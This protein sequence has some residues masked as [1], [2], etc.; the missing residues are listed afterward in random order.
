MNL[1]L[2]LRRYCL[3]G[4]IGLPV[5]L[6]LSACKSTGQLPSDSELRPVG[7]NTPVSTITES[8]ARPDLSPDQLRAG[9]RISISFSGLPTPI[10]KHEEQIREDG[11]INPPLLGIPIKAAGK[12]IGELQ[13]ELQDKYVPSYWRSATVT[14]RRME[15]YYFVGGEVRNPG[16]KPYLSQMT[17]LKAIEAGGGFTEYGKRSSVQIIRVTGQKEKVNCNRALKD[18]A[19]DKPIYPGDQVIV[20]KRLF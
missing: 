17:V 10:E 11:F 8:S 16:Q 13:A 6:L 5:I 15:S 20:P 4:S 14:L 9:D 2:K 3:L 19:L 18:P 1:L 7:T 12:K